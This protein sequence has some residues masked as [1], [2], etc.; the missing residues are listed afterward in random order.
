MAKGAAC[1]TVTEKVVVCVCVPLL[2]VT[3]TVDV[4]VGV[5]VDAASWTAADCAVPF[6]VIDEELGVAV[7]PAGN[8]EKLRLMFPV[9]P[10]TG[11]A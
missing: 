5:E 9:N 11:P 3:V 6:S 8:P 4:P 10:L 1:V 2:P 7:I